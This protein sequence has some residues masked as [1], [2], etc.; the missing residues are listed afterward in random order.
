MSYD[1]INELACGASCVF[2]FKWTGMSTNC[3][4]TCLRDQFVDVSIRRHMHKVMQA[5]KDKIRELEL[6]LADKVIEETLDDS[7]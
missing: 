4:C 6:E 2:S 3:G 5:Y 7:Q 1:K